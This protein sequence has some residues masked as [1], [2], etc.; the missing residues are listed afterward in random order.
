MTIE[1]KVVSA[2]AKK[3]FEIKEVNGNS[4][5]GK[6]MYAIIND[7]VQYTIDYHGHT[8]LKGNPDIEHG[9]K[10]LKLIINSQIYHQKIKSIY[11]YLL[12]QDIGDIWVLA[13]GGMQIQVFF[14]NS[15]GY[16]GILYLE[17]G[18]VKK[19]KEKNHTLVINGA[20]NDKYFNGKLSK[21]EQNAVELRLHKDIYGLEDDLDEDYNE[22]YNQ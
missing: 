9:C 16:L 21:F 18:N 7:G 10:H 3:G 4:K 19:P 8:D 15:K 6:N 17:M 14:G 13:G 1:Q 22:I 2:F 20:E 12:S 11:Q 5:W